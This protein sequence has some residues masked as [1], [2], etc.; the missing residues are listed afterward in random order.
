MLTAC[1]NGARRPEG[2]PALPISPQELARDAAT[3]AGLGVADVHLHVKDEQGEDVVDAATLG[4]V[5]A[6][7][8][9]VAPSTRI[10]VTP[11]AWAQP[12][13][14]ARLAAV[15]AWADLP[16]RHRCSR[17]PVD[18]ADGLDA[19]AATAEADLLIDLVDQAQ[20]A[21]VAGAPVL[22]HGEGSSAWPILEL[23]GRRGFAT[24]IGLEAVLVLPDDSPA[25]DDAALVRAAR[26][27][28]GHRAGP[29]DRCHH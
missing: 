13:P 20:H 23:A 29:A 12:D 6:A 19:A 28:L 15:R 7:V 18:V 1:V 8:C 10:G 17:V 25:P 24:R 9:S 21:G 26:G 3:L 22:L 11:G 14:G 27:L 5:I 16:H 4:A 2:H